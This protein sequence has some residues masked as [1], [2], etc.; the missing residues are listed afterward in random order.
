M[1]EGVEEWEV[2][3]VEEAEGDGDGEELREVGGGRD[4]AG[5]GEEPFWVE[6]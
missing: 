6:G 4:L 2:G 3:G 1:E 5:K